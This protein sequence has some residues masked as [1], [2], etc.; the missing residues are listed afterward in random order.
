MLVPRENVFSTAEA[1]NRERKPEHKANAVENNQSNDYD[2]KKA[3]ANIA[4]SGEF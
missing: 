3:V 4:R 2:G 1:A